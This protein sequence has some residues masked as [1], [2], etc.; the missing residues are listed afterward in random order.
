[1]TAAAT[2][3]EPVRGSAPTKGLAADTI[4]MQDQVVEILRSSAPVPVSTREITGALPLVTGRW[5]DAHPGCPA[6]VCAP[7]WHAYWHGGVRV[8]NSRVTSITKRLVRAGL[9]ERFVSP[10]KGQPDSWRWIGG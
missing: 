6:C 7:V 10:V 2:V 9:A 8:D 4:A 5:E 1:M 3:A